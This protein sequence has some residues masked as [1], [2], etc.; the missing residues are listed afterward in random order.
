MDG[1]GFVFTGGTLIELLKTVATLLAALFGG[2]VLEFVRRRFNQGDVK[3]AANTTDGTAIRAELR[4]DNKA[5]RARVDALIAEKEILTR[6]VYAAQADGAAA[7]RR[8]EEEA[9]TT[10]RDK[11]DRIELLQAH[12]IDLYESI[13]DEPAAMRTRIL[14]RLRTGTPRFLLNEPETPDSLDTRQI[15]PGGG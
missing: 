13:H 9:E 10:I 5:L 1:P 15:A 6:Q 8:Q 12:L 14:R 4:E 11:D 7:L 2:V 3:L